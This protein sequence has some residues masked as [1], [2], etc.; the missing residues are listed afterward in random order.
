[1]KRLLVARFA[2]RYRREKE[3]NKI[4]EHMN[5]SLNAKGRVERD[6]IVLVS[7]LYSD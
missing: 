4:A 5:I 3:Y 1:V 7:K 2:S 6:A